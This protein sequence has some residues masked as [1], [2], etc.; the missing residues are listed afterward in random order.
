MYGRQED[1]RYPGVDIDER[2]PLASVGRQETGQACTV[3]QVYGASRAHHWNTSTTVL[4]TILDH[5][6][7]DVDGQ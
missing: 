1:E 6:A 4:R 7:G 2:Y 5:L 3:Q